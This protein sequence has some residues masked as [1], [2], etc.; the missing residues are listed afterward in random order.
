MRVN[1]SAFEIQEMLY[2]QHIGG[3]LKMSGPADFKFE[4]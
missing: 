4:N 2:F 1:Y 3:V